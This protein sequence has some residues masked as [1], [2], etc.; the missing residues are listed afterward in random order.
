MLELYLSTGLIL[1]AVHKIAQHDDNADGRQGC[2]EHAQE[3]TEIIV[4]PYSKH[5]TLSTGEKHHLFLIHAGD[6]GKAKAGG[7]E[8]VIVGGPNIQAQNQH[9]SPEES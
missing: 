2:V 4:Q 6:I 3:R 5:S 1:I 8:R 9:C 7:V